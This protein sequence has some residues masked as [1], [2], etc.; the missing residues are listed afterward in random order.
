MNRQKT[1][2]FNLYP[3]LFMNLTPSGFSPLK[4]R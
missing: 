2:D 4:T 1:P 3:G